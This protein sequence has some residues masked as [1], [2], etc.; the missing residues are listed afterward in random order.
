MTETWEV[1]SIRSI[2]IYKN[3]VTLRITAMET[4]KIQQQKCKVMHLLTNNIY[5]RRWE[6][7]LE[8]AQKE[9]YQD[10]VIDYEVTMRSKP[11]TA[12]KI[13]PYK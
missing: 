1:L 10:T 9:K 5:A 13:N 6:K 2:E 7:Q 4:N 11:D 3:G 8:I 12:Q